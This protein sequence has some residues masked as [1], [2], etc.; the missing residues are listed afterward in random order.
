MVS[1]G[2][3]VSM[4]LTEAAR[5]FCN[6]YTKVG[7]Y[8]ARISDEEKGPEGAFAPDYATVLTK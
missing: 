4:K 6:S 1:G 7:F 5:C 2:R 8:L 3:K